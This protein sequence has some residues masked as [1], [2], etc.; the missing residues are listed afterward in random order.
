MQHWQWLV[1]D[2]SKLFTIINYYYFFLLFHGIDFHYF[3]VFVV[4]CLLYNERKKVRGRI[5]I[6]R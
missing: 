2:F 5:D 3:L 4:V 6:N 1:E